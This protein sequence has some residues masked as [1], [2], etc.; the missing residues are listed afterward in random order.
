[1]DSYQDTLGRLKNFTSHSRIVVY[2]QSSII[3]SHSPTITSTI[4]IS[5]Q[6]SFALKTLRNTPC[7]IN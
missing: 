4:K 7:F 6:E 1:M 2:S 3:I 5:Y